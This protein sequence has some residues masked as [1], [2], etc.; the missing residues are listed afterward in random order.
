MSV[1]SSF[2]VFYDP[3]YNMVR[4][5]FAEGFVMCKSFKIIFTFYLFDSGAYLNKIAFRECGLK[6]NRVIP[7]DDWK[8][9]NQNKTKQDD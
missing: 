6:R 2:R 5:F 1:T 9:K 8:I 4:D 7:P 3:G